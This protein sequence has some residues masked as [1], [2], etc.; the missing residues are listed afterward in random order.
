MTLKDYLVVRQVVALD[1][2][3]LA[4]VVEDARRLLEGA[5]GTVGKTIGVS[6][7]PGL[8]V[9]ADYD[10]MKHVF[11]NLLLNALEAL[12]ET[13]EVTVRTEVE[14]RHISVCIED[15]GVGLGAGGAKCFQPFFTTKK[16]GTGLGLAVCQKITNAY[17]GL[18]QLKNREGGGCKATV[19]LPC[20]QQPDRRGL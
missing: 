6:I 15:N 2:V 9:R 11:F 8:T 19:I 17:G 18:V 3:S 13:G 14:E 1:E 7:D 4:E 12:P 20:Q 10:A 5:R 16:N